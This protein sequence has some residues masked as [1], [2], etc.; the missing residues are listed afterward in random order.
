MYVCI[1]TKNPCLHTLGLRT[2]TVAWL[3]MSE[4]TEVHSLHSNQLKILLL[5][6]PPAVKEGWESLLKSF[7][8]ILQAVNRKR[9]LFPIGTATPKIPL[10]EMQASHSMPFQ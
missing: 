3:V 9:S 10:V 5:L 8:H 6:S 1:Y 7:P 4:V 2:F